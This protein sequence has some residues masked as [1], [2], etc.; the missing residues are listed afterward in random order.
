MMKTRATSLRNR[1]DW[2][3]EKET[4]RRKIKYADRFV[5]DGEHYLRLNPDVRKAN[6]DPLLHFLNY[7]RQEE[8]R[9]NEWYSKK[10]VLNS[11]HQASHYGTNSLDA[12]LGSDLP[13]KPRLLFVS[14]EASRT[15]APAII[16][17]LLEMFSESGDFECFS[18][19]DMGGERQEEFEA[20]SHT[21]VMSQPRHNKSLTDEAAFQEISRLFNPSGIFRKN[22]PICALVNSAESLRIAQGLNREGIPIVSLIHEIGASYGPE[23]LTDFGEI[24]EKVV[25]PSNFVRAAAARFSNM[26]MS[27]ALVRGQGLLTDG[28]GAMD[29]T[30][31][32]RL[33][34]TTLGVEENAFIVLNVGTMDLRKGGD[35]F[36]DTAS[37]CFERLPKD[38]PLYFLWYGKPNAGF[39]YPEKAVRLNG[40]EGRVRFMPSTSD[41]EQV[42]LGGDLFL[43]TAR[44]DPFPCVIHE[45]MACGLPVVAFRD[46]GG[47]PELIGDDCGQVVDMYDLSAMANAVISCMENP[48]ARTAQS[49]RAI[50][51]IKSD[52]DYLSYQKDIYELMRQSAPAPKSG[53]P[54][55]QAP[56]SPDHLVIMNASK[57]DLD[58]FEDLARQSPESPLDV[59]LIDGRFGKEADAIASRLRHLGNRVRHHQPKRDNRVSRADLVAK[60]LV[61]PRPKAVTLLNTL[62]F[63]PLSKMQVLAY[64]LRAVET[65]G[66]TSVDSMYQALPYLAGL[67]LTDSQAVD[68]LVRM[69]PM[70]GKFVSCL[71]AMSKFEQ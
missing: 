48:E 11:L 54:A 43:L 33:L 63:A 29:R 23:R 51:R 39:T 35:L 64:P 28:F 40:L 15:G 61:N 47:A 55:I 20:L 25:F 45:A 69:N 30:R 38:T 53:W 65:R 44:A 22:R 67:M 50:A 14:H 7:G 56:F 52:W 24:S 62:H 57:D 42:F 41:I 68:L 32:R 66:N 59:A 37:I 5:F 16:L 36:V 27:K 26:D 8:R 34:R 9:P 12:Y 70:S 19:L 3:V 18:I 60:L 13:R 46:G 10:Y 31:C 6:A 58:V 49:D 2:F 17:R 71:N 1:I 21:Y 4:K